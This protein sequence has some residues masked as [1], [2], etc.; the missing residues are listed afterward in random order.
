VK[1]AFF[2]CLTL[3]I[4]PVYGE[5]NRQAPSVAA[6]VTLFTQFQQKVPPAV[7]EAL[8]DELE[9]IMTPI[10]MRF[11]WRSLSGPRSSEVSIELAV[12]TFR[13]RCDA[14]SLQPFRTSPGALGWT[15][16]SD[17]V[18]LPFS[19]VDCDR[20]RTFVQRDLLVVVPEEREATFGR[21]LARVLAHELYHIFANTARHGSCG[22]GKSAYTVQELLADEFQFESH[23]SEA[24]RSSKAHAALE[25]AAGATW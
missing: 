9:A 12:V 2:L 1:Q 3:G 17:G 16:V 4:L 14:A 8:S 23:E 7:V 20:I 5:E 11:E 21:A 15:H 25:N 22:L 18:I 6:P 10:G 13:G 19:D 24:L